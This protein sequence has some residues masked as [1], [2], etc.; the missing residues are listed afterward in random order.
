MLVEEYDRKHVELGA[1]AMRVTNIQHK[2]GGGTIQAN[3][4]YTY[5]LADRVTGAIDNCAAVSYSYDNTNQLTADGSASYSFDANG[6]RTMAG[7]AT[8]DGTWT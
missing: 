1:D 4:T 8:N 3:F 2:D 5:D 6:N 7:Y